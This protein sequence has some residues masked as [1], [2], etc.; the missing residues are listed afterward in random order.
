MQNMTQYFSIN[1]DEDYYTWTF[2]DD[3]KELTKGAVLGV[4][5]YLLFFI[6]DANLLGTYLSYSTFIRLIA[7][8]PFVLPLIILARS[9]WNKSYQTN[10]LL[11]IG[12]VMIPHIGHFLLI[13]HYY[14]VFPQAYLF[15]CTVILLIYQQL[16][17]GL[18]FSVRIITG[19]TLFL[20]YALYIIF[21]SN[22][23]D[24][25]KIF[26][27]SSILIG[28]IAG[29][30]GSL[31][32]EKTRISNFELIKNLESSKQELQ[33]QKSL[34][35]EGERVNKIYSWRVALDQKTIKLS[36]GVFPY[37]NFESENI[38]LKEMQD[39]VSKLMHPDDFRKLQENI[40]NTE[41]IPPE[42]FHPKYKG[43]DHP[44]LVYRVIV[45]DEIIWLKDN[46]GNYVKGEGFYGSTQ[47]ITEQ[48]EIEIKLNK[49]ANELKSKNQELEQFL[50]ATTHDLKEPIKTI[51]NF[52]SL[53]KIEL[54]EHPNSE[55]HQFIE[56]IE[57]SS[58][59]MDTLIS[60]LLDFSRIGHQNNWGLINSNQV[61]KEVLKD[62]NFSITSTQANI[63]SEQLPNFNGYTTEFRVLLQNLI[64]NAIKFKKPNINPEI[65]I[66]ASKTEEYYLFSVSDNGIGIE[67]KYKDMIFQLFRRVNSQ[68]SYEGTG[69][70]LAQCKK[71][72]ELHKGQIWIES[73]QNMGTTF[74]FTISQNLKQ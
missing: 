35:A 66:N 62:L 21:I 2:P 8:P 18:T 9:S 55:A 51:E 37:Y 30:G 36:N 67:E 16:Y 45:D 60:G 50:Y 68:E 11:G 69:I 41:K 14:E 52:A 3:K 10:D 38:T 61:L 22:N 53:L 39:A 26:E 7:L 72:V 12:I 20:T 40:K 4:I 71:I 31:S 56:F 6:I 33:L 54:S 63:V 25:F 17:L 23:N 57:Q 34:L 42:E 58:N 43:K 70:G 28:Y 73:T 74:Y 15:T 44:H 64:S 46:T 47:D 29:I 65:K 5:S 1:Q 27:I 24:S 19:M 59:R 13:E 32:K 49:Q 48:K